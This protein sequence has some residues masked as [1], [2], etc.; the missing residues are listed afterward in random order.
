MNAPAFWSARSPRERGIL[1][2][3]AAA[4]AVVLV[5]VLVWLPVERARARLS[6]QLPQLRASAAEMRIQAAQADALRALPAREAGPAG[7][8][9]GLVA[10]GALAQG[11]PGARLTALDARRLRLTAEDA[12]WTRLVEWI[13][14]AGA[15][16]GLDVEAATIEALPAAGRVRAEIVLAAS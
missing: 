5:I 9:A 10:S 11:L 16:H 2:W 7:S 4:V 13:A 6:A 1:G 15:A 14:A 12:S 8:L 3:A